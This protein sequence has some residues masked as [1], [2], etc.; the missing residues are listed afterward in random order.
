METPLK[1]QAPGMT[2]PLGLAVGKVVFPVLNASEI[3]M[4]AFMTVSIYFARPK[5]KLPLAL[6]GI[7][8]LLLILQTIWLLPVLGMRTNM[9]LDGQTVPASNLHLIYIVFD[10]IKL[11]LLF[12]TGSLLTMSPLKKS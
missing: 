9:I 10:A 11:V 5:S 12:A 1:F 7:V 3:V 6:F 4:A 8:L 2:L